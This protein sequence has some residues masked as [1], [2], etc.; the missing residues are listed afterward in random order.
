MEHVRVNPHIPL[1]SQNDNGK[2]REIGTQRSCPRSRPALCS[3]R[4]PPSS[5]CPPAGA[6]SAAMSDTPDGVTLDAEVELTKGR[7]RE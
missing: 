3:S 2:I 1:G 7:Y 4:S 6:V 5:S